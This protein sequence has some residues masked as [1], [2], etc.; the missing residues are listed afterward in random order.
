MKLNALLYVACSYLLTGCGSLR[1]EVEPKGMTQQPERLVIA[2]FISPQDT[3]LAA[4][5]SFSSPVLGTNDANNPDIT[6]ATVTL[7]DGTRSIVLRP[8]TETSYS[9]FSTIYKANASELPIVVNRTY[10]LTASVPDGRRVS[11]TCTIPGPVYVQQVLIDTAVAT[12]YGASRKS[13]YARLRWNDVPGEPNFYRVAGT[14]EYV[15]RYVF[16]PSPNVPIRDTTVFMAGSWSPNN[17]SL[18]T[19]ENRDGQEMISSRIRLAPNEYTYFEGSWKSTPPAGKLEAYLLNVDENY[20]L[21]HDA[22]E[23]QNR[24][25]DNPFAEPVI[26]PSNIQ[27]GLGCFAGYNRTVFTMYIK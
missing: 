24:T 2:C 23:K 15:R 9:G 27:N 18:L 7:S 20:Y 13:Y 1:Q 12:E 17:G 8:T 22:V 16:Q 4:R 3:V 19:D 11:S 21:Y 25:R 14:N 10:T 26:I 6:N 5:V